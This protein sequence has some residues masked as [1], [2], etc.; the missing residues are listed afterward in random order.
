MHLGKGDQSSKME[1]VFP[2]Q[3]RKCNLGLMNMKK[4]LYQIL[5]YLKIILRKNAKPP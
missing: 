5:I 1:A 3:G 2:L 4:V